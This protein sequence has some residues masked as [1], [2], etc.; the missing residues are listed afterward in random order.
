MPDSI[1]RAVRLVAFVVV[2]P[3]EVEAAALRLVGHLPSEGV[4]VGL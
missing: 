1:V 4:A 2:T 3:P